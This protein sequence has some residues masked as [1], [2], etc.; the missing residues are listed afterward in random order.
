MA[1]AEFVFDVGSLPFE[2]HLSE[3]GV[4]DHQVQIQVT[5]ALSL[6]DQSTITYSGIQIR[7]N[8]HSTALRMQC[9]VSMWI[10]ICML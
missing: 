4:G 6:R 1:D 9:N 3:A 5:D 7:V 10:Y 8:P 2:I